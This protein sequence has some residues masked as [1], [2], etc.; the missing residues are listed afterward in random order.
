MTEEQWQQS[1]QPQRLLSW[2]GPSLSMRK[3]RL[4][5]VA[6]CRRAWG[7][8]KDPRSREAVEAAE[9]WADRAVTWQEV[10]GTRR[11]AEAYYHEMRG[12]DNERQA[13]LA[14]AARLAASRTRWELERAVW[15]V[16]TVLAPEGPVR[17]RQLADLLRDIAGTPFRPV[18]IDASW[19]TWGSGR[20]MQLARSIYEERRWEDMGVLGDALQEAGCADEVF[21]SHCRGGPHARGC[22]VVDALLGL[23]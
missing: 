2:V 20:V 11:G 23:S 10:I 14:W 9:A 4:Y 18:R 1:D 21:L 13:T 6:A 22:V 15:L 19:L 8:L 7:L 3:A 5:A 12:R 16:L 17:D